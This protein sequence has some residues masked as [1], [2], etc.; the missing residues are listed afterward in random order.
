MRRD[1][2]PRGWMGASLVVLAMASFGACAVGLDPVRPGAGGAGTGGGTSSS[3]T[4]GSGTSSTSSTSASSTSSTSTS[5]TSSTSASSTSSTTTSSTSASSAASSSSS[6]AS[7][8][9]SASSSSGGTTGLVVQYLCGNVNA[10]TQQIQPQF[11]ILN[12]GASSVSLSSLT[13]RYFYTKD[14]SLSTAQNFICDYAQIGGGNVS[15]VFNTFTGTNADEYLELHFAAGAGSLAAGASTGQIQARVFGT[16]YPTF[17]Q[18]NDYSFDPTKTS[19][20]DWA[21]V[22]LYQN[23]TLVWGTEP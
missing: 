12:K 21:N 4:G 15:A 5:S 17:S 23:G 19:F 22:T 13:L 10:S 6:S 20:A 1:G 2:F 3:S 14:G 18:A 11:Q 9:S 7:S 16:N 8:A